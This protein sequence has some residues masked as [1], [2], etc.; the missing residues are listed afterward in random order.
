MKRQPFTF[1]PI[2][3]FEWFREDTNTLVGEYHP[4]MTYNCTL[5]PRHDMLYQKCQE[6]LSE[7]KIRI[8]DTQVE[9]TTLEV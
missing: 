9:F 3:T 5:E 1:T 8:V 6:W 7:K 2:E 4:G